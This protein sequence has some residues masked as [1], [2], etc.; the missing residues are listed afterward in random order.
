MDAPH[1]FAMSHTG[2]LKAIQK[3]E[4]PMAKI[5]T[6]GLDL[7]KTVFQ[8]HAADRNGRPVARKKL[9]RKQVPEFFSALPPCLVGLEA[10]ASA[11]HWAREL[12]ALGHEVRLIPPQYVRPFVKTN[13][14]DASDAEAICEA[15]MRPTMRFAAIKSVEQQSVLL[16]HRARELL[17]RQRTMLINALRGHCGEFGIVAAQGAPKVADLIER[18][19]DPDD[20]RIPDLARAALGSLV[21]QLRNVQAEILD[22]EKKLKAW[23]RNNE[24]SRRLEAIPGVGVITATALVATIGD[25][26]QFCSG[27]Q[28]AAWL[29]LV[30][31]QHSSGGKERLGRISKRG[32][33]YIR[34]LLV[35][36]ARADLRWSRRR[37]G[38]RSAWQE[39]LLARRPTN[40]VLVAMANKTARVAWAMLRRGETFRNRALIAT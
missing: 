25:A 2:A 36:G 33:G 20:M 6:V 11:H 23:H 22:L 38:E 39:S 4:A 15:L 14:N 34:R 3:E 1:G 27:R 16:L 5:T 37:K 28:L 32:D 35:H 17:V 29:G 10:C 31:R 13:K 26:S 9:R 30:P 18:I 7:A 21:E 12:Q 24:A 8:V 19:E 40:V